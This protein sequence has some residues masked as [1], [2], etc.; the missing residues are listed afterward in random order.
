VHHIKVQS[1]LNALDACDIKY[2]P[3]FSLDVS[4]N[5]LDKKSMG[6]LRSCYE[7]LGG[8][9]SAICLPRLRM[10]FAIDR[11]LFLVD[12]AVH[13]NRYR[14]LT[15]KNDLYQVFTFPWAVSY[16]RLCRQQERA[17]LQAGLQER[18]WNG[19]PL[20][21]K[22]FGKSEEFGDLSGNGAAG[23][24]LNAYNDM[25]YDLISR[26]H[27]F[28]LVRIPVYETIMTGGS[29]KKLDQLLLNPGSA[30]LELLGKW[31]SR[32]LS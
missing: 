10:D 1:L 17:C 6:W 3:D 24:K 32:K 27:G 11:H 16:E 9:N 5:L 20:A 26:L 8:R 23:W 15:L 22:C 25:Q 21:S 29:L 7:G 12:D 19:P 4:Q 30:T 14:L 18:I 31:L 2:E 28:K 13:F